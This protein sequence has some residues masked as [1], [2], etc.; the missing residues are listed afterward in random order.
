VGTLFFSWSKKTA[1]AKQDFQKE[2]KKERKKERWTQ[3][4]LV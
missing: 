2:R 1:V 3:S 4:L